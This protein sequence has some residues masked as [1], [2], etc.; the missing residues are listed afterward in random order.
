MGRI[1]LLKGSEA[2]CV[3]QCHEDQP[4]GHCVPPPLTKLA[5]LREHAADKAGGK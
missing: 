5:E 1:V 4:W 2:L 3:I